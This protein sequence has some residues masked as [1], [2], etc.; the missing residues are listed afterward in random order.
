MTDEE[1]IA[2]LIKFA[3][4][5]QIGDI[6]MNGFRKIGMLVVKGLVYFVDLV[7]TNFM[8][9]LSVLNFRNNDIVTT[10]LDTLQPI[11][12]KNNIGIRRMKFF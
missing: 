11:T 3:E 4:Y 8:D 6:W 10:I 2:I 1:I 7:S 12:I 9:V 5:L